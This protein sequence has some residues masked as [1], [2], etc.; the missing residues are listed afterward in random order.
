[1]GGKV[2]VV[3]RYEDKQQIAFK[4]HTSFFKDTLN[5]PNV[6]SEQWLKELIVKHDLLHD[7]D[8]SEKLSED[9]E[10]DKAVCAPYYYG[11]ILI[12]YYGKTIANANNYDCILRASTFNIYIQYM[13]A[14]QSDFVARIQ[15]G[16]NIEKIDLKENIFFE[17]YAAHFLS[18]ALK[19]NAVIKHNGVLVSHNGTIESVVGSLYNLP[20]E[21]ATKEQQIQIIKD[22]D[23]ANDRIDENG[24]YK[25]NWDTFNDVSFEYPGFTI[26]NTGDTSD[27][28]PILDYML[29]S[30]FI[31]SDYEKDIWQKFIV[32][33][34]KKED[35]E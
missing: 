32:E 35:E 9:Y 16:D 14:L 23:K 30:G 17:F 1:M 33:N 11:I 28:Q 4:V 7:N 8:D 24:N 18:N 34:Q 21:N 26:M 12:D 6:L 31:L 13:R 2:A 15:H 27:T 3:V 19:H 25:T 20:L 29:K 22:Y 10:S 5:T